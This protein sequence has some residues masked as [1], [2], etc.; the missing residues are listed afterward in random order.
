MSPENTKMLFDA[1][2]SLY[3]GFAHSSH[4][5]SMLSGIEC[6][7][8]W[9]D[10]LWQLSH[11]IEHEAR[12]LEIDTLSEE[13]P[14]VTHVY[15]KYDSML[16]GLENATQ[17]MRGA[18]ECGSFFSERTCELCGTDRWY[19]PDPEI[20]FGVIPR[21]KHCGI[22]I[23]G[24]RHVNKYI[25]SGLESWQPEYSHNYLGGDKLLS[26]AGLEE[27]FKPGRLIALVGNNKN[28]NSL[29]SSHLVNLLVLQRGK[30]CGVISHNS[31]YFTES[32][33]KIAVSIRRIKFHACELPD[34]VGVDLQDILNTMG[35]MSL[36]LADTPPTFGL[37]KLF[38]QQYANNCEEEIR[39]G[40]CCPIFITDFSS[41]LEPD[42]ISGSGQNESYSQALFELK[43][44]AAETQLP[45]LIVHHSNEVNPTGMHSVIERYADAILSLDS[46]SDERLVRYVGN[47]S[48]SM[49]INGRRIIDSV[50]LRLEDQLL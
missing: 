33:M 10:L 3:R 19:I 13:W 23:N 21:C 28:H 31:K 8:G 27:C 47:S 42:D 26:L 45:I 30:T 22:T 36:T 50:R 11:R 25:Y 29:F 18:I 7:D 35:E 15:Q 34:G 6:G 44:L 2:P 9:L 16:F 43:Q 1:F 46:Q 14:K 48:F 38:I 39:R 49:S 40:L 41:L 5:S 24:F 12:I 17:E 32:L 37:L 20:S 4:E